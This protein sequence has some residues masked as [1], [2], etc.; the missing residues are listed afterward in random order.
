[1]VPSQKEIDLFNRIV[2]D[3]SQHKPINKEALIQKFREL[4]ASNPEKSVEKAIKKG[5]ERALQNKKTQETSLERGK[6]DAKHK[7]KLRQNPTFKEKLK[8]TNTYVPESNNKSEKYIPTVYHKNALTSLKPSKDWWIFIDET[9]AKFDKD[10]KNCKKNEQGKIVAVFVANP[11]SLPAL[12]KDWHAVDKNWEEIRRVTQALFNA[13][14]C[15]VLGISLAKTTIINGDQWLPGIE[16]LFEM[17]IRLLPMDG[18]TTLHV[19]VEQRELKHKDSPYLKL[20]CEGALKR[21]ARFYSEKAQWIEIDAEILGKG[22][23]LRHAYADAVAMSWGGSSVKN[24][25]DDSQWRGTCLLETNVEPLLEALSGTPTPEMWNLLVTSPEAEMENSFVSAILK[26]LGEKARLNVEMWQSFMNIALKELESK[27]VKLEK[28]AKKIDWL[29]RFCPEKTKVLPRLELCWRTVQL[30]NENHHGG[31]MN[32]AEVLADFNRLTELVLPE[33]APL[34]CYAALNLSVTFTNEFLFEKSR[35]ILEK[36]AKID[37]LAIGRNYRGRLESSLG[38]IE[39]FEENKPAALEHFRQAIAIFNELNDPEEAKM[40]CGQTRAYLLTTLMDCAAHDGQY[41]P[42]LQEEL[43]RYFPLPLS[44]MARQFAVSNDSGTKYQ[45]T[46]F[47]RLLAQDP[48]EDFE[49]AC[50]E[51]ASLQSEWKSDVGHPW[52]MIEFYR[53]MLLSDPRERLNCFR[54]AYSLVQNESGVLRV[55]AAVI[56]GSILPLDP[57][58]QNEYETLLRTLYDEFPLETARLEILSAQPTEQLMPLDLAE[59][60]LPFNFR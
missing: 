4:G 15:G 50:R 10:L 32:D 34:A 60:V 54:K 9:G 16:M 3:V 44:E 13:P 29:K 56:L 25:F 53:G 8:A 27:R 26:N 11:T 39:A 35:N 30:A 40:E 7:E 59:R 19:C 57:E 28:V 43:E 49:A 20:V 18:P 37:P 36:W 42:E 12:P 23:N 6:E 46:L 14:N 45:H 48:S 1:M 2:R 33:D 38:Q 21:F 24:L 58:V 5:E 31:V 51:Y 52:E 55:I 17:A 47:L 41:R 22:Q